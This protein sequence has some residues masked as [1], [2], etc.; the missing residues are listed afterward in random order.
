[1]AAGLL[2]S[3]CASTDTGGTKVAGITLPPLPA[4]FGGGPEEPLTP[5]EQRL[6]E[7]AQTF[8]K[9]VLGGVAY[10]AAIGAT[11]GAIAGFLESG[12]DM[13]ET[14]KYAA[15]GTAAGGV[16]GAIDGYRTATKQE[17]ARAQLREIEVMVDKVEAE[18]ARI[19]ESIRTTDAVINDSRAKLASAQQR[20]ARQEITAEQ[21]ERDVDG[22]Q[23]NVAE[24]DKLIAGIEGRRDEFSQVAEAMKKEGEDT[25]QLDAQ[26][27]ESSQKLAQLK[28][29]RDLLAQDLEVSRI[30]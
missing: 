19:E 28:S 2:L 8:N 5:A 16:Y 3:G 17:A 12:G 6:R 26:I 7:D 10:N 23:S 24:L 22:A 20:L 30:G 9:T 11:I 14:L 21:F 18:N 1:L 15:I 25:T 13:S 27:A 4:M 29:E